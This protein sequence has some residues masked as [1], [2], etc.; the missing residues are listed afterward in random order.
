MT[1]NR[2]FPCSGNKLENVKEEVED[3]EV[4]GDGGKDVLLG[5]D[6][7]LVVATHHHLRIESSADYQLPGCRRSGRLRIGGRRWQSRQDV[8]SQC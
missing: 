1:Q 8:E 4:D 7:E 5:G 6:R 3:V 2:S